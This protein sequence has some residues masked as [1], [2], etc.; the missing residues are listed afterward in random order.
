MKLKLFALIAIFSLVAICVTTLPRT[1]EPA[2]LRLVD[3]AD[4]VVLK[5]VNIGKYGEVSGEVVNSSKQ[6]LRDVELQILYS[7]RWTDEF[8]PGKD[9]PGRAEYV[10]LDKEIAPGQSGSFSHKPWPPL[11]NRRDGYF[12]NSVKLVGFTRVYR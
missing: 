11:D 4:D 12:E 1:V 10:H 2:T 6:A 3:K 8:H 9:D 7:W 5:N